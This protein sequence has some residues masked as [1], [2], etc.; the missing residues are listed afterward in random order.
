MRGIHKRFPGVHALKEVDFDVHRG[1]VHALVGENGAGKS[2]LM[3]ILAGV[4]EPDGGTIRLDGKD[5]AIPSERVSQEFGIAIVYQE[6]SLVT[7]LNVAENIYAAR[8]PTRRFGMINRRALFRQSRQILDQLGLDIDPRAPVEA[9]SPHEQQMVEIAKALS[10]DAQVLILDEPTAA[11]TQRETDT[12]FRLIERVRNHGVGVVYISHR[13]DEIF[14]IAGR[15]T[16]LKDGVRQ[17]TFAVTAVSPDRLISLMVGRE[18]RALEGRKSVS[19]KGAPR[20]E[21]QQVS[22]FTGVEDANLSMSGGEIVALAGLAGAGRTELALA[23][24]GAAPRRSGRILVDGTPVRIG[25][26][27][28]AISAGIGYLPEDRREAALFLDMSIAENIAAGRLDQY[29]TWWMSDRRRDAVANNFRKKLAIATPDVWRLVRNLSG[30]NQQ[31]VVLAKW[32]S[33][34]PKVLIADEPTKGIDVGAKAEVHTLLREL[35][36]RGTAVLLISSELLEVLAVAD[37]IVI[38]REGRIVHE[39]PR[40]EATEEKIMRHAATDQR[41]A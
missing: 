26:P 31:K 34:N 24:F 33:R 9:L 7:V 6:R 37:R 17:G 12:L 11:L 21:I 5:V 8:Q 4:H 15:V 29:G 18:L 10:L 3:H 22:D 38:M 27:A 20:L 39:L 19:A 2:T 23:I 16:V 41:A 36:D 40:D 28:D 1:E 30:G 35:A 25:S 32:L 13:L 14:T